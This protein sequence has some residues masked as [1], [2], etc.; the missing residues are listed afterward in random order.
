MAKKGNTM[1]RLQDKVAVITGAAGGQ[2][3]VALEIFASEGAYVV[4]SDRV[5][6]D[7]ALQAVLQK[8]P[9]RISYVKADLNNEAEVQR[10]VDFAM[11]KHGRI[12]VLYNNHGV[13]SGKP[14]L[15]STM[16]DFDY[17]M[18]GNVRSVFALSLACAKHMPKG[19]SIIH[20]SS[21]GGLVAFP[22]MAAYGASK[23]AVAHLARAMAGDLAPL[24]IRVNA[25]CPGVIDTPMPRG[26]LRDGGVDPELPGPWEAFAA[27]HM[28]KRIGRPEEVVWL[29]VYLA[30]DEASFMTGAV[31]PIDGGLTAL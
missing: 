28:L 1:N 27:M 21:V 2:G 15:E 22:T 24:G 31:I 3:K 13:M 17:V 9:D 5:D 8:Y 14:F 20:V 4:G 6:E 18:N 12:D 19:G 16:A 10:L 29:A 26:Y 11:Q 25:I 30:S 7:A 23:A